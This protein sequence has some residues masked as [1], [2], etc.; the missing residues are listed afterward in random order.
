MSGYVQRLSASNPQDLC[1]ALGRVMEAHYG[2]DGRNA[3]RIGAS[4]AGALHGLTRL[5]DRPTL[6]HLALSDRLA[7][8]SRRYLPALRV[9]LRLLSQASWQALIL[10]LHARLKEDLEAVRDMLTERLEEML[11]AFAVPDRPERDRDTGPPPLTP[12]EARPQVRPGAP[13]HL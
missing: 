2:P 12:I 3:Q 13:F 7:L 4:A 1:A 6:L 9:S 8:P 11:A 5:E 10:A